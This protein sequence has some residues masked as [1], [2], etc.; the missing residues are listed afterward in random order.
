MGRKILVSILLLA[1]FYGCTRDDICDSDSSPTTPLLVIEFRDVTDRISAKE[2][3]N[4]RIILNTIDSTEVVSAV[5]DTIVSV[6]LN[7][8]ANN[9]EFLFVLNS[10]SEEDRNFD[11]VT[12]VYDREEEYVNRACSFRLTYNNLFIDTEDEANDGTWILNTE[13]LNNV[14]ENS[15]EAHITIFH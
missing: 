5:T 12:L 4:L 2:V 7:T 15:N 14:I 10:T 9:S 1:I 13:I 3:N 8:E 11:K 6:P